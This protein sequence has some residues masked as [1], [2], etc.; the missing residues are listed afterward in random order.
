MEMEAIAIYMHKLPITKS[1]LELMMW[2]TSI[3]M[4]MY[5]HSASLLVSVS[6]LD[7]A[8]QGSAHTHIYIY[9]YTHLP[10]SIHMSMYGHSAGLLVSVSFLGH[11]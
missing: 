7:I 2:A 5:G 8:S 1:E 3:H 4:S 10:T 6:F 11:C 9:A